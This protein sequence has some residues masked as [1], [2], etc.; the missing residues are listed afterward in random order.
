MTWLEMTD[1]VNLLAESRCIENGGQGWGDLDI[2]ETMN[3]LGVTRL[4]I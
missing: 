2:F 3:L 1:I 4:V